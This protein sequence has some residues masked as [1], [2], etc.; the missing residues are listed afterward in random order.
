MSEEQIIEL[1]IKAQAEQAKVSIDSLVKSLV[2]VEHTI[3]NT[4]LGI[5]RIES[6]SKSSL[7]LLTKSLLNVE[8]VLTNIYL[9][10]G[11]LESKSKKSATTVIKEVNNFS[12]GTSG[13]ANKAIDNFNK[14]SKAFSFRDLY[15]GTR[16][17]VTTFVDWMNLAI[18]YTEQLNLFNVVFKNIK[19]NG[20]QTF[21]KIG[22]E[23]IKYQNKL[24]EAFGT[25][26][27]ETLY[28]QAIFESMG[29]SAGIKDTYASIMSET[30]T[31]LTYDL[32]SLFNS[33]EKDVAEALRAG[34][35]AGQS[36][37]L[38]KYGIDV[39]QNTMKPLLESL[40][41]NDRTVSEL[42]Y[43]EKEIL[44]YI[45]TLKQSKVA[46]GDMANTIESPS[47]QL[48]VFRQQIT[49]AKVAIQSLFIGTFS[50]ILPYANALVM[51]VKEV[52]RAIATLFG[53]K[54]GDYNSGIASNDYNDF[55]DDIG[56]S[57]DDASGKVKEL[58]RQVLSFDQIHNINE[59]KNN[60]SGTNISGG[61]DQRLLDAINGYDNGLDKVKMKATEI[62]DRIMEWLGLTKEIDPIT[63]EIN[64]KFSDT[65]STLFKIV[66]AF[67]DIIKYGGKAISGVFNKLKR[68]FDNG[69]F[70]KIIVG[71]FESIAK[72]LKFISENKAAQEI[73]TKLAEAFLLF[74]TSKAILTPFVDKFKSFSTIFSKFTGKSSLDGTSGI[75]NF[76]K[77]LNVFKVPNAKT[78]LKGLS[79]LALIIGGF[80]AIVTAI[81]LL[82]KIPGFNETVHNGIESIVTLFSGIT[83]ILIPLSGV[84]A[85]I[86]LLGNMGVTTIVKGIADLALIIIGTEAIITV[87]GFI[88]SISGDFLDEGIESMKKIFKGIGDVGLSLGIMSAA[89]MGAGLLGGMGV[90]AVLA[91]LADFALIIGGLEVILIALGAL[92]QIPGLD[93]LVGEGI[94]ALNKLAKGIGEFAGN[95]VSSFINVAFEGFEE[96]GT[97]LSNFMKNAKPFFE[98]V[99]NIDGQT[100]GCVKN[101]AAAILA[102]TTAGVMDSLTSWITGGVNLSKFADELIVFAP[103]FK[104]YAELIKGID[105]NVVESSSN[106]ALSI[107][108]FARKLPNEG[109]LAAAFAGENRLDVFSNYLPTFGK[110]MKK[111]SDNIKGIDNNLVNDTSNAAM[112]ISELAR[113]LPNDGGAI[114]GITGDNRL[115]I[116]SMYL[117][118]FGL[119]MKKYADNISG[120]DAQV[121]KNSANAAMSIAE[122]AKKL[123]NDGGFISLF[124]GD[125]KLS[126]FGRELLKFGI[127]FREYYSYVKGIALDNVNQITST[128]K[129]IVTQFKRVK[130]GD[131]NGT[132]KSFGS[133][134][135]NMASNMVSAFSSS[136][137]SSK[138]NSI[139]Y[140]FGKSLVSGIKSGVKDNFS[141]S[142]KLKSGDSVLKTY[143]VQAYAN[144]GFPEDGWFRA[145]H[146]EIMG[147]FDN[148]KSVVANN[149]QITKG[150]EEASYRGYMR[151]IRESGINSSN[152]SIEVYA[153]T[154]EGVII[155]RINKKT[156]QTG[157]CPINIP[158]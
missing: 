115:D 46:M 133:S 118:I 59:S 119:N 140:S 42:S 20:I 25:N 74:K 19:E 56:D 97:H 146:G 44:R 84:S 38:R 17:L 24:N 79:D 111:Y 86:T 71:I 61:I 85:G 78:I 90:T 93:W 95:I 27:T 112:S 125:N 30:M 91:G 88:K 1:Q 121:V 2:N 60:G 126:D 109:G 123:P 13:A 32:A 53:I 63:G 134:L 43:A 94:K 96:I 47:N 106:A 135:K 22:Q 68:D 8:N 116:F 40:G 65:N 10:L 41:I 76:S 107:A 129:E 130:D 15:F 45:A 87:V 100:V 158:Y 154:D 66:N 83:K 14:M 29:E 157:V 57:A 101:L 105:S 138:G 23:A 108:E 113:K 131:L 99:S 16:K 51:V 152:S 92:K 33:N 147:Q 31:N 117:P 21:S 137:S 75:T 11:R 37:P 142:L 18:D 153:H 124:T 62:R 69:I 5:G 128:I 48:K 64:W 49:E 149:Q 35:Y 82:T 143:K 36:K 6:T 34:V 55:L 26:K 50:K 139:G 80:T 54:L 120:I 58:K 110:N 81:G 9:D 77:K 141:L 155:D 114:M 151:A 122:M 148:G 7:N 70:G 89:I 102:F 3:T 127:S 136:F 150:I 103:K 52:T 12:K 28:M 156:K 98:Q 132:I 144:G 4:Y 67:K 72:L 145:N 104:Q 73:I 39:T